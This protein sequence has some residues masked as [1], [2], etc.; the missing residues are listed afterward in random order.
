MVF[1]KMKKI[2]DVLTVLLP[3]LFHNIHRAIVQSSNLKCS[4]FLFIHERICHNLS[5]GLATKARACK[6]A[7]QERKPKS[8]R[9]CEEI[10]FTLPRELSPWEL[11]SR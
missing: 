5:L 1:N 8:E 10:I 4:E 6:V 2:I 11:E 7:S 3:C 9:K